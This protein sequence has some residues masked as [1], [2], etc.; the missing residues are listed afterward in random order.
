MGAVF[1]RRKVAALKCV[2]INFAA[3]FALKRVGNHLE[4]QSAP[5]TIFSVNLPYH[6]E[7]DGGIERLTL[8]LTQRSPSQIRESPRNER[9]PYDAK[10]GCR[11]D[12]S[13][14]AHHDMAQTFR[15]PVDCSV[16][17]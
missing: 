2:S 9:E 8:P 5:L 15:L 4:R 17:P 16:G 14:P 12:F 1:Y 7:H 13:I 11:D 10:L 6:F 3:R